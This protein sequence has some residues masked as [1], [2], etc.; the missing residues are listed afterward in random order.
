MCIPIMKS[1]L[2]LLPTIFALLLPLSVHA[3]VSTHPDTAALLKSILQQ[4]SNEDQP[5]APSRFVGTHQVSGRNPDGTKYH[6]TVEIREKNGL[7]LLQWKIGKQISYGTGMLVGMTLGVALENGLAIYK[8]VGQS[9]GQSLIGFWS[10]EGSSSVNEEAILIGNADMMD[11]KFPVEKINGKYQSLREVKEGQIEGKLTISGGDVAKKILWN[12]DGK[13]S[14]CQGLALSDGLA[15]IS[16]EGLSVFEKRTDAKGGISLEGLSLT[17]KG[18]I[19]QE[20]LIP[21]E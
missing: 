12:I 3:Q 4:N 7:L 13:T 5:F 20:A 21:V 11:A 18:T 1:T 8:V 6:G 14:K 19:S 10:P 9:E 17:G 16:P 2:C 15:L